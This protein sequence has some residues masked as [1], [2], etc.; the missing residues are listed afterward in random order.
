MSEPLY[1]LVTRSD[2]DGLVCA[3]LLKHLNLINDILFVHPKDMQ[4]GK[5][6]ISSRDITTNLPY[7]AGCHLAFDHHLS[8]T[9]RNEEGVK[10][11]IIDADAPS[12]ARVV[13]QYY[14]GHQ[15]FP[16]A[17]DEM[18][19]AVDKG[20]S[21][22]F[23]REEVLHPTGWVLLNYLMDARTGLGRFREFRISNYQLMMEL[24]DYCAHHSIDDIL[25]LPDVKERVELYFDHEEKAKAQLQACS[26]VYGNLV[27][28][29]LRDQ[30]T[31]WATNRFMIYALYP[32]CN[33]SIHQMWGLR[34]QNTVFAIGKSI[35]SRTSNT[36][37]GELCLG[38]GG[39]GHFNAGTCQVDNDKADQV[40]AE[41]IERINQDG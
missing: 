16:T 38:Y 28:L 5:I 33:I 7:V 9:L 39:G 40:L 22:N 25:A 4:D 26:K 8:E 20:D 34:Q 6:E 23:N 17:W 2:F 1:R 30:N 37:V 11:H 14:G 36:N 27:V 41:L 3:V 18:M 35:L 10:N 13:W 12:A 31:I 21:A 15:A 29:D 24:I 19:E 32:Q